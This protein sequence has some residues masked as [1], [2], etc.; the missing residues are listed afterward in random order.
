MLSSKCGSCGGVSWE[1]RE[2]SPR[3][4]E[5]KVFFVRCFVCKVPI[6]TLDYFNTHATLTKLGKKIASLESG[7]GS[8]SS[9]LQTINNNIIRLS[10]K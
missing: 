2:E 8:I 4:S 5:F 6:G 3:G 10:N 7:V 9:A 1:I